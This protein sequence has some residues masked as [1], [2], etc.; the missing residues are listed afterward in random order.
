MTLRNNK[1]FCDFGIGFILYLVSYSDM[2]PNIS[3][4]F[5]HEADNF[6]KL[7]LDEGD[8]SI[9]GLYNQIY[10][11]QNSLQDRG[12]DLRLAQ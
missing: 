9:N 5:S 8:Q 11:I 12:Y 4:E 7:E 1:E 3:F 10:S 2:V 6:E